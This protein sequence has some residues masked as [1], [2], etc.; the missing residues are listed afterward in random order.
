[1]SRVSRKV[2]RIVADIALRPRWCI[3]PDTRLD[4]LGLDML[5]RMEIVVAARRTMGACVEGE[6]EWRTVADVITTCRDAVM[7]GDCHHGA[8]T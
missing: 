8:A 5:D 6:N 2:R 4:D 7:Y 1:M 3:R